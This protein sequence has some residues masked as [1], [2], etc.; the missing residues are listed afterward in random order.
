MAGEIFDILEKYTVYNSKGKSLPL[1][2]TELGKEL[3]TD[4][5]KLQEPIEESPKLGKTTYIVMSHDNKHEYNIF[6]E[7]TNDG[8][9]LSIHYS[10]GEQWYNGVKGSF[11]MSITDNGR[12]ILLDTP[13]SELD[14]GKLVAFRLLLNLELELDGNPLNK[15]KYSLIDTSTVIKL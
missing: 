3:M 9:K 6:V 7:E 15:E 12:G 5:L 14:Y 1:L 8:S 10:H 2:Q 4:L 11:I 13:I